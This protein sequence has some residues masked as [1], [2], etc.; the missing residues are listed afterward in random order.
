MLPENELAQP[1]ESEK[2]RRIR[3]LVGTAVVCGAFLLSGPLIEWTAGR[4]FRSV[5]P[6][7]ALILTFV[8]ILGWGKD[9]GFRR[10]S[11]FFLLVPFYGFYISAVLIYRLFSL[12]DRYWGDSWIPPKWNWG[13]G[14]L[15][16]IGAALFAYPLA[17]NNTWPSLG[18]DRDLEDSV[19]WEMRKGYSPDE[20]ALAEYRIR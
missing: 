19:S 20:Q 10:N 5:G 18:V 17:A 2:V 8:I 16:V 9:I 4:Q 13:M 12:P 3:A 15:A 11:V 14:V 1:G 6:L 7:L